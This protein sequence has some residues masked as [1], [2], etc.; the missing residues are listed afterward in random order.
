MKLSDGEAE[1]LEAHGTGT[2]TDHVASV[3]AQMLYLQDTGHDE[4]REMVKRVYHIRQKIEENPDELIILCPVRGLA[5][6]CVH[7]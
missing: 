5:L 3:L 2:A 6:H 4:V 1:I 7:R